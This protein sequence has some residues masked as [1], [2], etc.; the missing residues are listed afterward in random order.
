VSHVNHTTSITKAWLAAARPRTLP[1]ALASI[2]LGAFLAAADN[3]LNLPVVILAALTAIFL[4]ILSNLANDYGDS[5]HGADHVERLGPARAVQSGQ[6]SAR[7][8]RLAIV[9]VAL[10]AAVSGIALLWLAFGSQALLLLLLFT[11][12]GAVAIGAAVTY[13][14][15]RKPYGYAGLGDI[16]VLIFFGW[17]GVLGTYFLQARQLEWTLFLPATS[18]GLLAVAVLNINNIRDMHSDKMAGKYSIPVRLGASRARRYH[19]ALLAGAVLTAGLYV[20]LNFSSAWQ[21]LFLL[22]VPL[23]W[24]NGTNVAHTFDPRRLNPLLKQMSLTTLFFILT[25]GVGQLL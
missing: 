3:V 20:I 4:Q 16:A 7:A 13:T 11:L 15:G 17:V 25:F 2:A 23:L 5:V 9:L 1:L 12:L 10:L 18:C 14:A 6:I 8:M 22:A 21:F 24:R 19:W